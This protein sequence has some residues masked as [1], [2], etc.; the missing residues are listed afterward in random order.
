VV[1][2]LGYGIVGN[3][4][5]KNGRRGAQFGPNGE[6][7]DLLGKTLSR[8]VPVHLETSAVNGFY[9]DYDQCLLLTED[10]GTLVGVAVQYAMTMNAHYTYS[11]TN[12]QLLQRPNSK[13]ININAN[14]NTTDI[15]T[16]NHFSENEKNINHFAN[17]MQRLIT[18]I[19]DYIYLF[20]N[21]HV[22]APAPSMGEEY[23]SGE[24]CSNSS[25]S[26]SSPRNQLSRL[27]QFGIYTPSHPIS[28]KPQPPHHNGAHSQP[29]QL[30]SLLSPTTTTTITYPP[31]QPPYPHLPHHSLPLVTKSHSYGRARE[32]PI[33]SR[34]QCSSL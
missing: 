33:L 5:G 11:L 23:L 2:R 4:D 14:V 3:F 7:L 1:I 8:N 29:P 30:Q 16:F 34:H 22:V 25:S 17:F 31:L 13:A 24:R 20:A 15:N 10:V 12:P 6:L 32:L 19:M 21:G 26:S 18:T 9:I 28:T 27:H